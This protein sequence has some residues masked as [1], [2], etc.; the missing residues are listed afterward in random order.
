M[1]THAFRCRSRF[2][3]GIARDI[4]IDAFR[5]DEAKVLIATNVLSR[6]VDVFPLVTKYDVFLAATTKR[7]G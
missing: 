7:N 6:G 2:C 3:H 5:K 1:S 4:T